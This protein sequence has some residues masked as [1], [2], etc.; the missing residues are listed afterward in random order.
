MER[1]LAYKVLIQIFSKLYPNIPQALNNELRTNFVPK[2]LT[3]F[4]TN[5]TDL[6]YSVNC[7]SICAT[8]FGSVIASKRKSIESKIIE[9][10]NYA[11]NNNGDVNLLKVS[12]LFNFFKFLILPLGTW[13]LLCKSSLLGLDDNSTLAWNHKH[14]DE[15]FRE[16]YSIFQLLQNK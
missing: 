11:I 9:N 1:K 8:L 15:F 10:V 12:F 7:L 6:Y 14:C 13:I 5:K 16:K 3:C 4:G 2:F